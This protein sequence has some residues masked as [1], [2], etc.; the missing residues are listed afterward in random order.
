[1]Y[2]CGSQPKI[3]ELRY[4]GLLIDVSLNC[5]AY[6]YQCNLKKKIGVIEAYIIIIV[7]NNFVKLMS[8][9]VNS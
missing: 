1:M 7:I 8:F 3:K 9:R 5:N 2:T 6:S 4:T